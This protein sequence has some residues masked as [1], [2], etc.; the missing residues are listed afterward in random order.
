MDITGFDIG[1]TLTAVGA[2]VKAFHSGREVK[3]TENIC[4]ERFVR[5]EERVNSHETSLKN[6]D[7]RFVNLESK[8]DKIDDKIDENSRLLSKLVG[9]I[10]ADKKVEL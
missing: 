4:V 1:A 3:K 2:L 7:G 6:W 10:C 5:L 8:M 9:F